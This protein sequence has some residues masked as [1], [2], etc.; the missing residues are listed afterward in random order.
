MRIYKLIILLSFAVIIVPMSSWAV[1]TTMT[2]QGRILQSNGLP[3]SGSAPLTFTIYSQNTQVW[4]RTISVTFDNGYY[5]VELTDGTPTLATDLF[6][7]PDLDLG[8]TLDDQAE[9]IPRT[10]IT[11]VPRAAH[12]E[13]SRGVL[14]ESGDPVISP[15][16]AWLGDLQA[17]NSDAE[18]NSTGAGLLRWNGDSAELEVCNG[19]EWSA[20][21]TG[22]GSGSGASCS[23]PVV[24][25]INPPQ[26]EPTTN[27]TL[28]VSGS[29]FEDGCE[30]W[31]GEN[32]IYDFTMD[33]ESQITL[34]SGEELS[35]GLYA[36]R[37]VN[38]CGL[39]DT[40]AEALEVDATPVWETELDQGPFADSRNI[41][42]TLSVSDVE[43]SVTY[44]L[45]EYD[46]P[47]SNNV[48]TLDA[49]SG[50]FSW[51]P[52]EV[53][54]PVSYTFTVQVTDGAQTPHI[55]ERTFNLSII[56]RIGISQENP[57][58][59]CLDIREVNGEESDGV[60][61]IQPS[62]ASSPFEV[63]CDM[64]TAGG[65]W[66]LLINRRGGYRN[67]ESCGTNVT[68]FTH[69]PC[70]SVNNIGFGESYS[71]DVDVIPLGNEYLFYNMNNSGVIDSDDAFIIRTTENLFPNTTGVTNNINVG[72]VCDITNTNCDTSDVF[73]KYDGDGYFG[74]SSC[75]TQHSPGYGGNYGYC[76]NGASGASNSWLG[77]R[78]GYAESGLWDYDEIGRRRT[79]LR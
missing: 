51:I 32:R 10:P 42:I 15:E 27:E 70:G 48:P 76:H 12:A 56:H 52:E 4:T 40:L 23:T 6:I 20:V 77:N 63:Y 72:A 17:K 13:W 45:I 37:V 29:L 7:E 69:N 30:V 46:I 31:F 74:S 78:A 24:S 19:S 9:F 1:P 43:G 5:S 14:T 39:R 79:F 73:W 67:I 53:S 11:T 66:T 33:S 25:S 2:H 55:I 3:M 75:T 65:G 18:C 35:S 62:G 36:L 58:L 38:P 59:S 41:E 22:S 47:D 50:E 26:I 54:D 64:T 28:T 61:W 21:G 8:I 57:G 60:F 16:G 49:N 44:E 68:A 34:D 71:V